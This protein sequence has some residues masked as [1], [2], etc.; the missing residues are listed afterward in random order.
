MNPIQSAP[1][2]YWQSDDEACIWL[3]ASPIEKPETIEVFK[4]DASKSS[5]GLVT[6]SLES[7]RFISAGIFGEIRPCSF[8]SKATWTGNSYRY[9]VYL[10]EEGTYLSAK[11]PDK[12]RPVILETYGSETHGIMFPAYTTDLWSV[13]AV[14][15]LP[16]QL[17]DMCHTIMQYGTNM[18]SAAAKTQSLRL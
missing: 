7:L 13:I 4:S 10:S 9:G 6:I 15:L 16:E 12:P 3:N 11:D 17:W 2:S 8:N 14:G 5:S 18:Q 1:G